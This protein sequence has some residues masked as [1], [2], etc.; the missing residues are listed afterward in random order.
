MAAANH[1]RN[2]LFGIL[3][4]QLDFISRDA[5][6][7]AMNAWVLSKDKPLGEIL[8]EQKT[9]A[10]DRRTLLEA[11]VEEHLKQH[12]N[13]AGKSLAAVSSIGSVEE[14]LRKIP[15]AEVQASLVHFAAHRPVD[16]YATLPLAAGSAT[17]PGPVDPYATLPQAG[18][19]PAAASGT[20]PQPG[21]VST[22]PLGSQVQSVG[23]STSLG[24]RFRILRLHAKG[25]L[26][27]VSVARDAEL[28]REVALKEIQ[29]RHADSL[30]S[31]AR[32][33]LEAEVTGALEH[34]GI[35]PVY[36]L[37]T[38]ADG[39][40]YYAMRFIRGDSLE[41]A[42]R[43]FHKSAD[44][45][46]DSGQRALELRGLLGRFVDVCNAI[47]YAHS[48]GVLH[49]DLKP[50]NIMLGQYG[51]TLVVDWGLAKTQD[52]SD[53]KTESVEG[54]VRLSSISSSSATL[55]GSAVGTPQYM[56]PEQASGRL[57]LLGPPTDVYSLGATLYCLL[58]GRPPIE[59]Q[60]VSAMLSNVQ[61]GDFPP[62]RAV[63]DQVP[64]PLEAICL[65]A[66]A[67]KP[68]N[69]YKSPKDLADDVE[70]WLADEPVSAYREA[71]PAVVARWARKH[72]T[73]VVSSVGLIAAA[74]IALAVTTVLVT[75]EQ[76][77]TEAAR[78]E[79]VAARDTA[80]RRFQLA[81]DTIN[82]LVQGIQTKLEVRPTTED[83][84]KDL[85]ENARKRVQ[86][87]L[88]EAERQGNPDQTLVWSYF[89]MGDVDQ[90]IGDTLSAKKEYTSGSE[91]A[92]KL[93]AADPNNS[94]ALSDL[95]I[96][97]INLGG[98]AQQL[99]QTQEA[100]D[101]YQ[102][103]LAVRQH[104]VELDPKDAKA[105]RGLSISFERLGDVTLQLGRTQDALDYY[106]KMLA[107]R[108]TLC[109][110]DPADI[111]A[112]YALS[113]SYE[114]L[115]DVTL[116][117]GQTQDALDFFQKE[118][119]IRQRLADADPKNTLAQR[120][121]GVAYERLGDTL[122]RLGRTA[123]ARDF[124]RKAA[125]ICESLA[126]ADPKNAQAQRDMGIAYTCLGDLSK[127][128]G[129]KAEAL[130]FY[131]K[132]LA[133][134]VRM[135]EADPKNVQRQDDLSGSYDRLGDA[136]S[137]LGQTKE[138]LDDYQKAQ[139]IR[140]RLAE[141]DPK[142][143]QAQRNLSISHNKLGAI[144]QQMGQSKESLEYYQKALP[145]RVR[146]AEADPKNTEAQRDLGFSYEK[147]GDVTLQLGQTKEALDFYQKALAIDARLAEAD[148][149]NVQAH[150]DLLTGYYNAARGFA[151][152]SASGDKDAR[153]KNAQQAIDFLRQAIAKGYK[154]MAHIKQDKDLDA[155]RERGDFR[156]LMAELEKSAGGK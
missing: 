59:G 5:L 134:Y 47:A 90:V 88:H 127:Q 79:A 126:D 72:K 96:S 68:G 41:E 17:E 1:D 119:A 111:P 84:R 145:I 27:Q 101:D 156:K 13:D 23:G 73:L 21:G 42:V 87:L 39:R 102:K 155:L 83:L 118:R 95:G 11:L 50:G 86:Q 25:G 33:M 37:G 38:Y 112:Q 44:K 149:K 70:H 98:I 31:R 65:K 18:S 45:R 141:A 100:L 69:R 48:R 89:R 128:L 36:G 74:A 109:E 143:V 94:S 139:S 2:L 150:A 35:V 32:F 107:I 34:P 148:P 117:L 60:T 123:E 93:A 104:R 57:D 131:R 46:M 91:L 14:D 132:V 19:G 115:G 147:L 55:M 125:A 154:D 97:Y 20:R 56:S 51:E 110:A 26:G 151:R 92:E 142:N 49:R 12:G 124:Y 152:L 122:Q 66:M 8:V 7:S 105:Q 130:D 103:A 22:L 133:T 64:R 136:T 30:D 61:S 75:Q 140:Q 144:L 120:N 81:L 135:A 29:E 43:R 99:G 108:Q 54:P 77:K 116:Q 80:R 24:T 3:A 10:A 78:Q 6:L 71:W 62:P 63:N 138:A 67:L 53:A 52:S 82:D 85:L 40:P 146:L 58:T 4:V 16:P 106:R 28:S 121:L 15:D 114:R 9:L 129:Q 153:E 137:Q 113:V 76:R